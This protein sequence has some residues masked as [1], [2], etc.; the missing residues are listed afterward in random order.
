MLAKAGLILIVDQDTLAGVL[1]LHLLDP[2]GQRLFLN[3]SCAAGLEPEPVSTGLG[4]RWNVAP[5]EDRQDGP[6]LRAAWVLRARKRVAAV[7]PPS[8]VAALRWQPGLS[9]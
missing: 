7:V 4:P 3:S 5:T 2:I 1:G 9:A 6:G 8:P